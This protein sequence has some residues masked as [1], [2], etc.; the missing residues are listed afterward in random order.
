MHCL[1][2]APK[3]SSDRL[4]PT[5]IRHSALTAAGTAQDFHLVPFC[6]SPDK[7]QSPHRGHAKCIRG[8]ELAYVR[9]CRAN[10]I[11]ALKAVA[12]A[13]G[14]KLHHMALQWV[15]RDPVVTSALIGA[16]RPEQIVDNLQALRAAPFTQEELRRIDEATR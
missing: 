16:S 1:P 5:C 10:S 3:D 7:S 4:S 15:L 2:R 8:G 13:R 14:Q 9:S 12:D 6:I 11:R